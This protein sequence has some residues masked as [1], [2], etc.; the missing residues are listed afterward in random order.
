MPI[1]LKYVSVTFILCIGTNEVQWAA[2]D[3]KYLK[4]MQFFFERGVEITECSDPR[5]VNRPCTPLSIAIYA[6][7]FEMVVS[8]C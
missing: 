1:W 7:Q 4:L 5:S 2:R 8:A 3:D 6:R